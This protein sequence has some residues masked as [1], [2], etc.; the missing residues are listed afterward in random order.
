MPEATAAVFAAGGASSFLARLLK[1][2]DAIPQGA[3]ENEDGGSLEPL[4]AET[5]SWARRRT[6]ADTNPVSLLAT[7]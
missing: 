5:F 1:S 7:G 4:R 3:L 2:R 6:D